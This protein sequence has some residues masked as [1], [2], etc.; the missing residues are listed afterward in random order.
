MSHAG[1]LD[2]VLVAAAGAAVAVSI[3]LCIKYLLR[4]G[5]R[6]ADHIKRRVLRW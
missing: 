2:Y 4:G 5:E 3:G 1:W 6:E